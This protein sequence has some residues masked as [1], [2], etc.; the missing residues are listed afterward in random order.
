M[1]LEGTRNRNG[2]VP[3]IPL[4]GK[5]TTIKRR[6]VVHPNLKISRVGLSPAEMVE[7]IKSDIPRSEPPTLLD[8]EPTKA[9]SPDPQRPG[10]LLTLV[11]DQYGPSSDKSDPQPV[12]PGKP[13]TEGQ[14]REKSDE[15]HA[16]FVDGR[17]ERSVTKLKRPE[18]A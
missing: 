14:H 3:D 11:G 4:L 15:H 16:Q 8:A 7:P 12:Q 13:F 10:H 9:T 18:I 2:R 1:V 17:Y 6:L 5:I